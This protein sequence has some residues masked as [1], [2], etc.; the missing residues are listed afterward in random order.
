MIKKF[1]GFIL[2]MTL[3]VFIPLPGNSA[4]TKSL[5]NLAKPRIVDMNAKECQA[6]KVLELRTRD[7]EE[8]TRYGL[9]FIKFYVPSCPA[10]KEIRNTWIKVADALKKKQNICV[11]EYNCKGSSDLCMDLNINDVPVFAW[12]ENGYKIKQFQGEPTFGNLYAFARDMNR[13]NDTSSFAEPLIFTSNRFYFNLFGSLLFYSY[14][15]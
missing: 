6:G 4:M 9:F 8:T 10:C 11:A 1:V 2:L 7:F 12:F 14:L 3:L 5:G 13:Y 15:G